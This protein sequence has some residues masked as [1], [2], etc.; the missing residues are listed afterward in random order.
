VNSTL[1]SLDLS[2]NLIEKEGFFSLVEGMK[3]NVGITE[4]DVS[5]N[6]IR[7]TAPT[8]IS[9][10]LLLNNTLTSM[11]FVGN[12]VDNGVASIILSSLLPF[13]FS[14]SDVL[15]IKRDEDLR[16]G[17]KLV[18]KKAIV[19]DKMT[20]I[21]TFQNKFFSKMELLREV[22]LSNGWIDQFPSELCF[23]EHLTKIDMR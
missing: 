23:C 11:N 9:T 15:W 12:K 17:D 22:Y 2:H 13:R 19:L 5:F 1:T 4:L 6:D 14:Q 3:H 21:S 8:R 20:T 16:G 10:S 7:L 18:S